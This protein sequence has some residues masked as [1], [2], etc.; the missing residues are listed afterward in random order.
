MA[1][2]RVLLEVLLTDPEALMKECAVDYLSMPYDKNTVPK[3][4]IAGS[5]GFND[6]FIFCR[7]IDSMLKDVGDLT[8]ISGDAKRGPDRMA[9]EYADEKGI[10]CRKF[11]ANWD[12]HGKSAG[13]IR[14]AEMAEE[15]DIL[16]AMWDGKSRGTRH[17]I[18][19][20]VRKGLKVFV[21]IVDCDSEA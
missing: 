12:E 15:G 7:I 5:R 6:Y 21:F 1:T 2:D 14:N 8:I 18:D 4:I 13:Y 17:M 9:I 11:P 16:I 19:L 10:L 20:A 3:I